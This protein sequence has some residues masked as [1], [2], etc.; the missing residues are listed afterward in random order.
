MED[1]KL[2]RP[3]IIKEF[4]ESL[5]GDFEAKLW[6]LVKIKQNPGM[7]MDDVLGISCTSIMEQGYDF[8]DLRSI[9]SE[10]KKENHIDISYEDEKCKIEPETNFNL[11]NL[12]SYAAEKFETKD[13]VIDE[14]VK[15]GFELDEIDTT[16]EDYSL[17]SNKERVNMLIDAGI[18]N[19]V[20]LSAWAA[21]MFMTGG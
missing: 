1:R 13:S 11:T 15:C 5:E 2:K 18:T 7:I 21:K 16:L 10:L 19:A 9:A 12:F 20:G 3:K 14:M 8:K 4:L 6:L 17:S